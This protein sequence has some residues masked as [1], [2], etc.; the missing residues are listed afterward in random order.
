VPLDNPDNDTD[1]ADGAEAPPASNGRKRTLDFAKNW[2]GRVRSRQEE[3]AAADS[4]WLAAAEPP[5]PDSGEADALGLLIL[6]Y[7]YPTQP[8]DID[9][10][11]SFCNV[12]S[13]Y[14]CTDG[15]SLVKAEVVGLEFEVAQAAIWNASIE[16]SFAAALRALMRHDRV[17]AITANCGFMTNYQANV[18]MLM[19]RLHSEEGLDRKPLLMGTLALGPL[20]TNQTG[21]KDGTVPGWSILGTDERVVVVTANSMTLG[22]KFYQL[23]EQQG[24]PAPDLEQFFGKTMPPDKVETIGKFLMEKFGIENAADQVDEVK[25]AMIAAAEMHG[26][27]GAVHYLK[28]RGRFFRTYGAQSV[29]GFGLPVAKGLAHNVSHATSHMNQWVLDTLFRIEYYRKHKGK[30]KGSFILFECT[31]LPAYS[32]GVRMATRMPVWDITTL[33]TCLMAAARTHDPTVHITENQDFKDCLNAWRNPFRFESRFGKQ[34]KRDPNGEAVIQNYVGGAIPS[35]TM[36]DFDWGLLGKP[37]GD[38][39]SA[40]VGCVP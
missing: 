23:M 40:K 31:E 7:G 11:R 1:E 36:E 24:M 28:N 38:R 15:F 18:E 20:F 32:N 4:E 16:E 22:K 33:A 30:V 26:M 9:D 25:S 5:L 8:G 39:C 12:N 19:E 21:E 29:A 37:Q 17:R 3:D 34:V 14:E 10:K 2:L 13:F 6:T 35:R 27:K